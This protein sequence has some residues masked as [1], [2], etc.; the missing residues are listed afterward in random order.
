MVCEPVHDEAPPD[1]RRHD[2]IAIWAAH[3]AH[4][5]GADVVRE[6]T[7]FARMSA[8]GAQI[9]IR[10]TRDGL[11]AQVTGPIVGGRPKEMTLELIEELIEGT[12]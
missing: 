9:T 8:P 12:N 11:T 7:R 5:L 4:E 2:V 1:E 3:L 6:L 10:R